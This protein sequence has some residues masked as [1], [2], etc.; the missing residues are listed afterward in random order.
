MVI[1]FCFFC[2]KWKDL[3]VFILSLILF[4]VF[5][6]KSFIGK[7]FGVLFSLDFVR[8]RLI[9]LVI[10]V[11]LFIYIVGFYE[12]YFL[13]RWNK[14]LKLIFFIELALLFFFISSSLL[15]FYISFE[16]ILVPIFILIMRW[17]YSVNRIQASLFIFF[18]TILRSLPFLFNLIFTDIV[19]MRL[20]FFFNFFIF[21]GNVISFYWWGFFLL[22][23]IVK[24]PVFFLHL[25]LPKAHVEAPILGSILLAGVLLKL[26]G[27][28]LYKNIGYLLSFCFSLSW[29]FIRF[30]IIGRIYM[31]FVCLRQVD[32]KSLV[33]YSSVVHIGP[34]LCSFFFILYYNILGGVF[35]ILSHGICSMILFYTLNISYEWVGR[36]R[37]FL[38]R[39]G[40]WINLVLSYFW[41]WFCMRNI[42]CPPSFNFFSEIFIILRLLNYRKLLFFV[43]FLTLIF[44]GFYCVFIYLY[45]NHGGVLIRSY[46]FNFLKMNDLVSLFY[47]AFLSFRFFI[48]SGF[49]LCFFSLYKITKCGFVEK[50]K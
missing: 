48:F 16:L 46:S 31:G 13:S 30:S 4:F 33:A 37:F 12:K 11:F 17:G 26:G 47:G 5:S 10:I 38:I 15:N 42:G 34:V 32:F 36:R 20:R 7:S 18:Y 43:F 27:Y 19:Y 23:F 8:L 39:G 41:F 28:G 6:L 35:L 14:I 25:W 3:G 44:G 9:M 45:F 2:L 24:L 40:F 50:N 1:F 49:F 22:V 29:F 21:G